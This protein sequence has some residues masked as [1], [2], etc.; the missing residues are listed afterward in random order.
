MHIKA[1]NLEEA[2]FKTGVSLLNN[3]IPRQT[4]GF[5][6]IEIGEPVMVT[7]K[8]P[9]Q[10]YIFNEAR[11][12]NKH[13]G[14]A[15]SL[16]L[17]NGVNSM[18]MVGKVVKNLYNF[19][20]DGVFMRAGYGPRLR[21]FSGVQSDYTN[22][23]YI[24]RFIAA[25]DIAVVDQLKYVV[26]LLRNSPDSRQAS[27]TIH[28][29]AKDCF[30]PDGSIKSTKDQPCTRLIQFMIVDGKL[31]ATVYMRSN[32]FLWGFS[33]V[34]IFNFTL[35]QEIVAGLVGVPIGSYHHIANNLH[36]YENFKSK[37]EDIVSIDP[38]A[39]ESFN[40]DFKGINF[41][42]F[43][44][45]LWN[46]YSEALIL[47][48]NQNPYFGIT[49]TGVDIIDDMLRAISRKFN[50]VQEYNTVFT[51]PIINKLFNE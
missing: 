36:Y 35:L 3:G 8:D 33:A 9:T 26:E 24:D 7:I 21:G 2:L 11:G 44:D 32:D 12:W 38:I 50:G 16:W 6:C 49:W 41:K 23:D 30:N 28:D 19:S 46:G 47:S 20:D 51:N 5:D 31:D 22:N 42:T 27:V 48:N 1:N 40:Y 29:P 17:L 14:F 13:L 45:K 18:N 15:E 43:D 37:I 10:R 25:E 34:N 39:T 4:R